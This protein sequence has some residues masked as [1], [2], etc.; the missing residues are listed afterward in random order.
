MTLFKALL[1]IPSPK[2]QAQWCPQRH[3][4]WRPQTRHHVIMSLI[5]SSKSGKWYKVRG[6][7]TVVSLGMKQVGRDTGA[8]GAAS[9]RPPFPVWEVLM[10]VCISCEHPSSCTLTTWVTSFNWGGGRECSL[11]KMIPAKKARIEDNN[12]TNR[13]KHW[14]KKKSR[15]SCSTS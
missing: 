3:N 15:A 4:S 9:G 2:T 13:S 14:K 10:W 5:Q 12:N 8:L 1:C 6:V 7:R 11:K